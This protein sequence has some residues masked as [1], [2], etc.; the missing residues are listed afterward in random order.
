VVAQADMV[1]ERDSGAGV[2]RECR[3]AKGAGKSPRGCGGL[4]GT[5]D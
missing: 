5:L 2:G 4:G 3:L 1:G